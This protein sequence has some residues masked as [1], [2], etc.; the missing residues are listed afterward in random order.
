MAGS[1]TLDP[2]VLVDSLV[3]DVIDGLRGT[4]HPQFGVRPYRVYTIVRTWSGAMVGQGTYNDDETEIEPQPRVLEW[5]GYGF[6][7][8]PV[9]KDTKGSVK[10]TEVSLSYTHEDLTGGRMEGNQQF[11]IKI[12][13]ANGQENPDRYFTHAKPPFVDRE[14]D[15]GW[16]LW[17]SAVSVP[18]DDD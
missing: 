5:G 2:N 3:T 13:E 4:L 17:L 11:F 6:D 12:G 16:V 7:S 14:K 18:C 8:S 9:G 10:V 15:M 1:A